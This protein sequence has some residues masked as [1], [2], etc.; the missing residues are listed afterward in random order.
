MGKKSF[1]FDS[2]W[3]QQVFRYQDTKG[4][5]FIAALVFK[6]FSD[7]DV[8]LKN[9]QYI[10]ISKQEVRDMITD[11]DPDSTT[12]TQRIPDPRGEVVRTV[13]KFSDRAT[14]ENLAK[15]KKLTGNTSAG[16][17][18]LIWKFREGA[19]TCREP[20]KFW[21]TSMTDVYKEIVLNKPVVKRNAKKESAG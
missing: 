12:Y 19:H 14:P 7:S 16:I 15:Y 21:N 9:P 6:K 13:M 4:D 10:G 1:D 18:S 11:N 8:E 3:A 17:T 5:E 20:D 2:F